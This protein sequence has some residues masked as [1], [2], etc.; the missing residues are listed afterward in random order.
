[1]QKARRGVLVSL[2][3][4]LVSTAPAFAET[5]WIS[6]GGNV[7]E[8]K[9]SA[10][11]ELSND[12][13]T[14]VEFE[15]KGFIMEEVIENGETFQALRFPYYYTT[16]EVGKPQLPAITE[17]IGI[18]GSANVRVT[19]IDSTVVTLTGYKVYPFQ[20]PLLEEEERV[21][22]DMDREFY[23]QNLF[24]PE[25]AVEVDQPAV[26]RDVRVVNLRVYPV[27]Y[28]PATGELKVYEKLTVKLEY[29][30][31]SKTNV[32]T[33]R[34]RPISRSQDE[35]YRSSILNYNLLDLSKGGEGS[36]QNYDYLIIAFDQ[37]VDNVQPLVNWKQS[38]GIICQVFPLTIVGANA[39][40]IKNWIR[41]QYT[42]CNISYVLLVGDMDDVP[43]YTGYAGMISDYWYALLTGNDLM[44]E[45][46]V[47]R[48][49]SKSDTEIDYMVNKS[50]TFEQNPP[51]GDWLDKALL[52][53]HKQNAPGK[54]QGC[55][56]EIRQATDTQ[57]GTYR[58]KYPDF[59]TAY[60][61]QGAPNA[62]VIAAIN[63]GRGVVN[64]RGHGGWDRWWSW[65]TAN[66]HFTNTDVDNL[67]NGGKTPVVFSIACYNNQ[68]DKTGNCLGEA[69][70]KA[71]DA[72]VAFLGA[73]RPSYT[74][75]NHTY[76]KELFATIFD[77]GN[78]NIGHASNIAAIRIIQG[79][80]IWG[81]RNA[82]MYLWLGEPSL[83]Y[84]LDALYTSYW[85]MVID[86]S[87]SMGSNNSLRLNAAK[88]HATQRVNEILQDPDDMIALATFGHDQPLN[89]HMGWTR[90][91]PALIA[92]I[93]GIQAGAS[94]VLTPLADAACSAATKLMDD[95][96]VPPHPIHARRLFLLTDGGE[97]NSDGECS[98][99]ADPASNPPWCNDLNSW[100]C[101]AWTK[102]VGNMIV[103]IGYFGD[104]GP[105]KEGLEGID[106]IASKG[107]DEDFLKDLADSTGGGW[108]D[109][110]EYAV[111]GNGILEPGEECEEGFP[112]SG[113]DAGGDMG[114]VCVDCMCV[115][116][117][118][119]TDHWGLMIL[120]MLLLTSGLYLT[121]RRYRPARQ[122]QAKG[123]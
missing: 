123:R 17:M 11:V 86:T 122:T 55:K 14:V 118:P 120:I 100:H 49:S 79:H 63:E 116:Q 67:T 44:P 66:E 71:D 31:T 65:N 107:E 52:V 54:Y 105:V 64:Y 6:L 45:V 99:P 7:V 46:A 101:L 25:R 56:E 97:N 53:A 33:P 98:G 15:T 82:K 83:A 28:N 23:S 87:G 10:V 57:S 69:F 111:C 77:E 26:W 37:F 1:M 104:L 113:S 119:V 89:V 48:F 41:V 108:Y 42:T 90:N 59:S 50:V 109:P 39:N 114:F 74:T 2:I 112:C 12:L 30:G 35:M 121:Y 88:E 58:I 81:E 117:T 29:Y 40:A 3:F 75:P 18:P 16:L 27:R 60:G 95:V 19:V 73:T 92:D 20:T 8:E 96:P 72:A 84:P 78:I 34:E 43:T 103:D 22:F 91:G 80:G 93:A 13:E 68:L 62:S 70:T 102:L 24:Y 21:G 36:K 5:A 9:P 51:A 94:G 38:Q 32:L 76:D 4:V 110:T 106:D 85:L 115:R 61:A 47:G